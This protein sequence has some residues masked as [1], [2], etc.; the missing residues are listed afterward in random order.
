[1]EEQTK[2]QAMKE[3]GKVNNATASTKSSKSNESKKTNKKLM[4]VSRQFKEES[5]KEVNS[6]SKRSS[7]HLS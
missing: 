3:E 1:M 4:V 5:E 2:Q 7:K 6:P